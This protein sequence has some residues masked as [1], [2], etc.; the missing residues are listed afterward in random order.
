MMKKILTV[1]GFLSVASFVIIPTLALAATTNTASATI[2]CVG[3]AVALRE[4][5]LGTAVKNHSQAL[6]AVYSTRAIELAGAYSNT[7]TKAL[8]AGVKVAWSDFN[9]SV[10]SVTEAWKASRND[11]WSTFRTAVKACKAT[12]DVSDSANSSSEVSG[13]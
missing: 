7:T 12:G 11:A 13:Q 1:S 2:A 4:S 3:R 8:Q 9:K 6:E 10:K 5:A